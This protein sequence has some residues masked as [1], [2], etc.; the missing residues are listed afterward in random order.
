[1]NLIMPIG[2]VREAGEYPGAV[3]DYPQQSTLLTPQPTQNISVSTVAAASGAAAVYTG[4]ITATPQ[5]TNPNDGVIVGGRDEITAG[6]APGQSL[7]PGL[8]GGYLQ[9]GDSLVYKSQAELWVAWPSTNVGPFVYVT[10]CD[11]QYASPMHGDP[12]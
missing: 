7:L 9:V 10:V 5:L 12:S 8:V 1:M 3:G 2:T 11:M 6:F 4:S